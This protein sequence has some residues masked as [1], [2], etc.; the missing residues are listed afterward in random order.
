M[1]RRPSLLDLLD[2][3]RIFAS[4][5]LLVTGTCISRYG[6]L[7]NRNR[8]V[9][10]TSSR[11]RQFRATLSLSHFVSF[12]LSTTMLVNRFGPP[13]KNLTW[14]LVETYSSWLYARGGSK[15]LSLR[16]TLPRRGL[17]GTTP[18]VWCPRTSRGRIC[19]SWTIASHGT[20][21][22]VKC[23]V[24]V[25][26]KA[27]ILWRGEAQLVGDDA[28]SWW[29]IRPGSLLRPDYCCLRTQGLCTNHCGTFAW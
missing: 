17:T 8:I 5:F 29:G 11:F 4:F 15:I 16:D 6:D 19:S 1:N 25:S 9:R 13:R 28:M 14:R 18:A 22:R 12:L 7:C 24:P 23:V 3:N 27:V 20:V 26:L 2:I 21:W 10:T